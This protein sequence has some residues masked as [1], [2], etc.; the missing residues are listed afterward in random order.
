MLL[1]F[2]LLL[3]FLLTLCIDFISIQ[4]W[5][6]N[7][8]A[9]VKKIQKKSRIETK[10]NSEHEPNGETSQENLTKMKNENESNYAKFI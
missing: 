6:Q 1:T 2:F 9:K 7:Q 10:G 5:F 3:F 4:V 8:R